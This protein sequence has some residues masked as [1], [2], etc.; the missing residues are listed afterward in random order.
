MLNGAESQIARTPKFEFII[1]PC[2]TKCR[3]AADG[4]RTDERIISL[5]CQSAARSVGR[6][7]ELKLLNAEIIIFSS[8]WKRTSLINFA[9]FFVAKSVMFVMDFNLACIQFHITFFDLF[10]IFFVSRFRL[11]LKKKTILLLLITY[12]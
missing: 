9:D 7:Q 4:D 2:P 10:L 1:N 12:L 3:A 8:R 11:R 6:L 5:R